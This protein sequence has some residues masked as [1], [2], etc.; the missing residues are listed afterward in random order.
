MLRFAVGDMAV[1]SHGA[2]LLEILHDAVLRAFHAVFAS[3]PG[4]A[5]IPTA[6]AATAELGIPRALLDALDLSE[7]AQGLRLP[8]L[9]V[10]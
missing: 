1:I 2:R 3:T 5:S 10:S 8:V 6:K 4:T 9:K 7:V